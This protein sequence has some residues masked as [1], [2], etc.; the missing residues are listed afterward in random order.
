MQGAEVKRLAFIRHLYKVGVEQSNQPEPLNAMSL[1][2]FHD[3][4]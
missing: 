4:A 3:A 2:S 1:L